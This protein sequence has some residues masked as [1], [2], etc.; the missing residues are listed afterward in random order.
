MEK[1]IQREISLCIM[2][3]LHLA[4]HHIHDLKLTGVA[5]FQSTVHGQCSTDS[6]V[7]ARLD[8]ATD[9]T[10]SRDLSQCDHFY[11]REA[12]SSPL[13]LL[14][15]LVRDH[16]QYLNT[17]TALV[18]TFYHLAPATVMWCL[19]GQNLWVPKSGT[20]PEVKILLSLMQIRPKVQLSAYNYNFE[21]SK[22]ISWIS[23]FSAVRNKHN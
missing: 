10:L 9:V 4:I 8:I 17:W 6:V 15:K 21:V 11:S 3:H 13:A 16:Q 18:I 1:E 23:S 5:F 14:Q 22:W 7:N 2:V 12:A 19:L 20:A